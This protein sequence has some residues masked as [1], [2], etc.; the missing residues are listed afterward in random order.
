MSRHLGA[1]SG[2]EA[3]RAAV[4]RGVRLA[5][6]AAANYPSHRQC[7]SCHHQT[8][9][10]LAMVGARECG[11][12]I[13]DELLQAQADFS[14]ESF[15][16]HLP[17]MK[18][19]RG[20]GGRA[21][22]T[23][24]GLW[25][26]QLAG[27]EPDEVTGTMVTFL[28]KTQESDGRWK[29]Q[30]RRPPMEESPVTCTVLSLLGIQWYATADQRKEG[31]AIIQKA[32]AWLASAPCESQEDRVIWLWGLKELGFDEEK[33]KDARRAVLAS[34]HDDGGFSQLD[35]MASD[36]YA[37]GQTLWVLQ[38]TGLDP[39]EPAYERGVRFLLQ[40]QRDDG[41]WL[42]ETRSRPVQIFFENGDPHGK[43]Q[44][45]STPATCWAVAALAAA[46]QPRKTP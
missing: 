18:E 37:T 2:P 42:V 16:T 6:K 34:Q 36:A 19:G 24:Y 45:I 32:K 25:A 40:T 41:S 20:V 27:Y 29:P 39:S 4:A 10:M 28:L 46:A 13:D 14:V 26:L 17:S 11:S 1:R 44:F 5:E 15:R 33:V 30:T 23:A 7:F 12:D 35:D 8:L 3:I 43:N 21:L 9:P 22:T 38:E 31:D